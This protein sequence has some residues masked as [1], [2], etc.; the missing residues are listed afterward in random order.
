MGMSTLVAM[1]YH[2]ETEMN[3][4]WNLLKAGDDAGGARIVTD[5]SVEQALRIP[6][7]KRFMD[8]NSDSTSAGYLRQRASEESSWGLWRETL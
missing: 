7:V 4:T 3:F 1:A 2:T 5:G 6:T 8:H